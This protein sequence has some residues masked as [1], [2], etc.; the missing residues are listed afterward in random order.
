ME[1]D[2]RESASEVDYWRQRYEM[3]VNKVVAAQPVMTPPTLLTHAESYEAGRLHGAAAEREACAK[4]CEEFQLCSGWECAAAIRAR[5]NP[6]TP[7]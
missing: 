6:A 1:P 7:T 3:L 4:Q 5:S 2:P